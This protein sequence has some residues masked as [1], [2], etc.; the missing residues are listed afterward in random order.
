MLLAVVAAA[1]VV[2]KPD[3]SPKI[4]SRE[5]LIA[6]DRNFNRNADGRQR[7]TNF[8]YVT[9]QAPPLKTRS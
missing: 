9:I 5:G 4:L 3:P 6:C 8:G 7:K 1:G 2:C